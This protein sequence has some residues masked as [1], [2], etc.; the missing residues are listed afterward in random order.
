[1]RRLRSVALVCAA[2]LI[3]GAFGGIPAVA[4]H[5]D[6]DHSKNFKQLKRVPTKIG[7]GVF[8]EGSDLAIQGRKIIAG[9][10]QG[11]SIYKI[12]SRR[13]GHLKQ[14]GFHPCPSSQGDVSVWGKHAFVSIDSPSTN[15]EQSSVCNNT[16]NSVGKEGVRVIDISRPRRIKQV[17]FVETPCGS[18]THTLTPKGDTGYIYVQSYP[19]GAPSGTCNQAPYP[20]GHYRVSILSFP[21]SDPSKL[22]LVGELNVSPSIGCHDVSTY[23]AKNIAVAACISESQI[24]DIS[25]PAEP[26]ILAHIN[27]PAIQ[28]HHSSAFTWDGKYIA[29]GDEAGGAAQGASQGCNGQQDSTAGAMWFYD[30]SDPSNPGTPVGHYALPRIPPGADSPDEADYYRCTTHN[31]NILPMKDPKKYIAVSSYY[32]G[33]LSVIDF[34]DPANPEEIGHYLHMP[35]GVNSDTWSSYWYNGKVYT[36]DHGSKLGVG[37]YKVTGFGRKQVKFFKGRFNPQT[38][39]AR[40]R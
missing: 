18:H 34:S 25:N 5:N 33:G 38:Q 10:Y 37:K 7:K 11:T 1:M 32:T 21:L 39:I 22:K 6:D 8:A 13:K 17:R 9:T 14:I 27:N 31:F 19:L 40:F 26:E 30:I 4:S 20:A 36:N 2:V 24:W 3:A 28:I 12:M 23:P 15:S 29:L 35:S 16:N